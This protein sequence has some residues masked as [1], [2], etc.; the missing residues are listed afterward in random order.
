MER[1]WGM[2]QLRHGNFTLPEV[3]TSGDI[4]ARLRHWPA[5]ADWFAA[6]DLIERM[7]A[8]I[9]RLKAEIEALDRNA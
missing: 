8:D 5:E 1:E 6:A 7:E 2:R 9:A 4:V 3:L